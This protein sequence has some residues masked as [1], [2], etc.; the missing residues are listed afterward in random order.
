MH[1]LLT[2]RCGEF[3]STTRN[4]EKGRGGAGEDGG[5]LN[6]AARVAVVEGGLGACLDQTMTGPY[7]GSRAEE[8][9]KTIGRNTEHRL[10]HWRKHSGDRLEY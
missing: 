1:V 5:L 6:G 9:E 7:G 8:E 4:R 10:G 2:R 3:D